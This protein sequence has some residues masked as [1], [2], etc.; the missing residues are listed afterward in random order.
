M[1][2][3]QMLLQL[4]LLPLPAIVV[5]T[6]MVWQLRHSFWVYWVSQFFMD[7]L[8]EFLLSPSGALGVAEHKAL[9]TVTMGA[10]IMGAWEPAALFWVSCASARPSSYSSTTKLTVVT[11]DVCSCFLTEDRYCP[12]RE[13]TKQT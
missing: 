8:R 7:L 4:L 2:N 3:N 13:P 9:T 6:K 12:A 1:I 5:V 10:A 11:D